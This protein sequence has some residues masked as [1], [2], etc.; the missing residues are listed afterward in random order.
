MKQLIFFIAIV[1]ISGCDTLNEK[2]KLINE[3]N[4][5]LYYQVL[6]DTAL[7]VDL[8]LEEFP[9]GDTVCPGLIGGEGAWEYR[10]NNKSVDSTLYVF[11]FFSKELDSSVI[12][13]HQ[14]YRKGFK[15]EDLNRMNWIITYPDDF[16]NH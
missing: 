7:Y 11:I 6:P 10:I 9:M 2:L 1:L 13:N 12:Q 5:K 14:F 8:F 3:S 4:N 16:K 15:V